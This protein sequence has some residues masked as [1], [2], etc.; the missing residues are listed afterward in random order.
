MTVRASNSSRGQFAA[1]W[2][3]FVCPSCNGDL[4][5]GVSSRDGIFEGRHIHGGADG[6]LAN[7]RCVRCGLNFQLTNPHSFTRPEELRGPA[8]TAPDDLPPEVLGLL[9]GITRELVKRAAVAV[10]KARDIYL[11]EPNESG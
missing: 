2:K 7:F 8:L 1:K 10:R 6:L 11:G 3:H 5:F 9:D 4:H